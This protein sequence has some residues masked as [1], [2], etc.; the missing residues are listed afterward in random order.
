MFGIVF[1]NHHIKSGC[2]SH[3]FGVKFMTFLGIGTKSTSGIVCDSSTVF[4][5]VSAKHKVI[6]NSDPMSS[7]FAHYLVYDFLQRN[8]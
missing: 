7:D 1:F 6:D 5:N 3:Q 2:S 4:I 8:H